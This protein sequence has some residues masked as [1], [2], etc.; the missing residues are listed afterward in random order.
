MKVTASNGFLSFPLVYMS[1]NA[2]SYSGCVCIAIWLLCMIII[3]L[4]PVGSVFWYLKPVG[5]HRVF[6][7]LIFPISMRY[8]M[9]FSFFLSQPSRSSSMCVPCGLFSLFI[10][11]SSHHSSFFL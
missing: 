2:I 4:I 9:S 6:F 7:A 1:I 5:S 8:L 3:R 10:V 11:F